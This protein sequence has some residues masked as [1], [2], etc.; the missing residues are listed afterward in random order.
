M[1]KSL[2]DAG[3]NPIILHEKKNTQV[4]VAWMDEEYMSIPHK[5]IEGQN[6]EISP[7]D[8]IVIPEVIWVCYGT[9]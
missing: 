4:L 6:L 9:N 3:F 1:A 8:F 2:L 5:S 7:E